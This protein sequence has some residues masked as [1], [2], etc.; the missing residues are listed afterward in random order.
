MPA[1]YF[2]GSG[3]TW[4][5]LVHGKGATRAEMYRLAAITHRLGMPTLSIGYRNDAD[6]PRDPSHRHTFGVTEWH[7]LDGAVRYAKQQGASDIVLGGAS[8]GGS[9]VASYL[10]QRGRRRPGAVR[11]AGRPDAQ[12]P[13]HHRVRRA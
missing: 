7:D 12:P 11:G 6:A 8:M 4:A 13:R 1:T 10:R 3:S 5:V 2:P 9:I